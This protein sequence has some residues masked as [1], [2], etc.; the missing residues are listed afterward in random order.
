MLF[1]W[2]ECLHKLL[3]QWWH[4]SLEQWFEP[5]VF[6]FLATSY[7]IMF[8]CILR[9]FSYTWRLLSQ[10]EEWLFQSRQNNCKLEIYLSKKSSRVSGKKTNLQDNTIAY[11]HASIF[12]FSTSQIKMFFIFRSHSFITQIKGVRRSSLSLARS[13]NILESQ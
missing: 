4:I 5:T 13:W 3:V 2:L 11:K 7:I 6:S 9:D 8:S 10:C 12:L 1:C